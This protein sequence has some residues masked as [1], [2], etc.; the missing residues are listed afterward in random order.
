MTPAVA[1]QCRSTMNALQRIF[2]EHLG[3]QNLHLIGRHRAG[4]H[5]FHALVGQDFEK[6]LTQI[7][8]AG[9][10]LPA[11]RVLNAPQIGHLLQ[12]KV[13]LLPVGVLQDDELNI[14]NFHGK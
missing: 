2:T 9:L 8:V 11:M 7:F 10:C 3:A 5:A 13:T 12:L 6:T 14:S 4:A 1:V